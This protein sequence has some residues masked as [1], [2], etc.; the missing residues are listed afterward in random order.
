MTGTIYLNFC[1]DR[2]HE[3]DIRIFTLRASCGAVYCNRSCLWVCVCV[4]MYVG[5]SVTTITRNCV[6]RSSPKGTDHFQLIKFWPSR[7]PGKVVCGGTKISA[8]P[9]YSQRAVFGSPTSAFFNKSNFYHC[10]IGTT[11]RILPPTP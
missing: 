3:T 2:D 9:Y 4:C 5:R 6:Y 1:G 8:P 11:V 7:A 10:R